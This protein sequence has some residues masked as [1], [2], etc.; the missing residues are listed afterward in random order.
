LR[1]AHYVSGQGFAPPEFSEEP[2]FTQ[3]EVPY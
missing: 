1:E 3:E 2:E